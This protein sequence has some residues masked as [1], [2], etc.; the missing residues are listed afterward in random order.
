MQQS[1]IVKITIEKGILVIPF[2]FEPNLIFVAV[3]RMGRRQLLGFIHL[4]LDVELFFTP[5]LLVE[6]G[7]DP[8]TRGWI[9]VAALSHKRTFGKAKAPEHFNDLIKLLWEILPHDRTSMP[10]LV[11]LIEVSKRRRN[12]VE[13][14]NGY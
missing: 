5:S 11:N 2:D 6:F 12:Q 4:D 3:D 10:P 13:R 14:H 8:T 7:I 1:K 9:L